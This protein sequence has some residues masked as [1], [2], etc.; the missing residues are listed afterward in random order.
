V[1]DYAQSVALMWVTFRDSVGPLVPFLETAGLHRLVTELRVN[2][3]DAAA[4]GRQLIEFTFIRD[5]DNWCQ[6]LDRYEIAPDQLIVQMAPR[7]RGLDTSQLVPDWQWVGAMH[8][9]RNGHEKLQLLDL[10]FRGV[11]NRPERMP[12]DRRR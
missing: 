8:L 6:R 7:V 9:R 11:V 1:N 10:A 4:A 3:A 2:R 5:L 12:S